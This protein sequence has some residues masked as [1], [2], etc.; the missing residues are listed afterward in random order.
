MLAGRLAGFDPTG[1]MQ[2]GDMGTLSDAVL[3][4]FDPWRR[5]PFNLPKSL[6]TTKK[7]GKFQPKTNLRSP[8]SGLAAV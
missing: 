6:V 3:L 4:F 1:G 5:S 8:S 7:G 2:V